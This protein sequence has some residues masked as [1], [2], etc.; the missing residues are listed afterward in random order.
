MNLISLE[1]CINA[2]FKDTFD[3]NITVFRRTDSSNGTF[4]A[5]AFQDI[6]VIK[7]NSVV[8]IKAIRSDSFLEFDKALKELSCH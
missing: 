6:S 5:Y 8:I 1:V 2:S 3:F 4:S 7:N